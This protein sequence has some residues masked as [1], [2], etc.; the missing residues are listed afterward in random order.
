GEAAGG[1]GISPGRD[2]ERVSAEVGYWLGRAHWGR[3]IMTEVVRR[4]TAWAIERFE[5]T[6]IF[7]LPYARNRA[8]ARVLEKAGYEL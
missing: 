7:A 2:V 3:G 8:S 1:I 5:L 4:F 6:R